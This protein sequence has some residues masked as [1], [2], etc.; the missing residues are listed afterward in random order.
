MPIPESRLSC[1][2]SLHAK[3]PLM[4]KLSR[5]LSVVAEFG[6]DL[7]NVWQQDCPCGLYST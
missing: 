2:C 5:H 1:L 7:S 6:F 3:A 4:T